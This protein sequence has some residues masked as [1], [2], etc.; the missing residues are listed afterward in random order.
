MDFSLSEEQ[1][2]IREAVRR[3]CQ[4]GYRFQDRKRQLAESDF[5]ATHWRQ[6][7]ELG[8]LGAG[9]PERLGGMGGS[10]IEAALIA[11]QF[12]HALVLEPFI[13]CC[14]LAAQVVLHCADSWWEEELLRPLIEGR[15]ILAL[16]HFEKDARGDVEQVEATARRL[17]DGSFELHGCK[18]LVLGGNRADW[19][20]V[21]ARTGADA[22]V[23]PFVV[24]TGSAGVSCRPYR[25]L[26]G[27][28]AADFSFSGVSLPPQS[29][30]GR[31]GNGLAAVRHG[32]E[33]AVVALCAEAVGIM[34]NVVGVTRDYLKQRKA[35][36]TT[37]STFQALQHRLADALCDVELSRSML[38]RAMAALGSE[39]ERTRMR[40]TAAAKSFIGHCG[41][42][43][44]AAAI[45]LH[46]GMGMSDE[47][48]VG[49]Q[50][51]RL[52]QIEMLFGNSDFHRERFGVAA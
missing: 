26:D 18:T 45:Q 52:S 3:Y 27:A 16:A 9:L 23:S 43:V 46:G 29:L 7:A 39:D 33:H 42:L 38:F 13:P 20:V 6:F 50:F 19:L 31:E 34:D 40:E 47:Y 35:Y 41:R 25:T 21:T 5:S 28:G 22:Q 10:T 12:G 2:G 15:S 4:S 1:V 49:H 37:L 32:L 17:A 14:V 24:R 30:L 51:K 44:G 8:L 36:G 48:I 11:E